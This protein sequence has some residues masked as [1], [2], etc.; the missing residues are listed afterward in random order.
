MSTL[1]T[2]S[3]IDRTRSEELEVG[4]GCRLRER[5]AA[6]DPVGERAALEVQQRRDDRHA[7]QR[8]QD[9][10]DDD[11]EGISRAGRQAAW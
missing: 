1:A 4:A 7:A 11:A 10:D 5:R 2:R 3:P 6:P 8:R 9:D